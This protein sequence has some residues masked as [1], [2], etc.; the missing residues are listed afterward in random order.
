MVIALFVGGLTTL[1]G[2]C[3]AAASIPMATAMTMQM[4]G[5][6]NDQ[7]APA[8]ISTCALF[9]QAVLPEP[10]KLPTM[11]IGERLPPFAAV[12]Q[13]W[14]GTTSE[15]QLPPPRWVR[16]ERLNHS[17]PFWRLT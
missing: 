11:Q 15:P 5:P 7:T 17:K 13:F 16:A 8:S 14:T 2:S 9:C 4:D 12:P 6:C 1:T 10:P 3:P